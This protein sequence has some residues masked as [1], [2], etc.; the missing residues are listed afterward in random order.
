MSRS[1]LTERVG[2]GGFFF[3]LRSVLYQFMAAYIY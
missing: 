3:L 2:D 1:F